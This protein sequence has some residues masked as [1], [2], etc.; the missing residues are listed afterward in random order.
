MQL[1][2]SQVNSK[3]RSSHYLTH[4]FEFIFILCTS[5]SAFGSLIASD[6]NLLKIG[7]ELSYPPFEMINH[8]GEPDGISVKMAQALGE[9]LHQEIDIQN[10]AFIGLVPALKVGIID[11]IISSLSIT[12]E[13]LHSI[14]FSDPYA[15]I[16]LSLLIQ[17]HSTVQ[18]IKDVDRKD[19]NVVVKA[20]TSGEAFARQHLISANV[21]I[22]DKETA[23]VLEVIQGKADVFIYDQLSVYT[24]W[25]KNPLTTRANLNPFKKEEWAVGIRKGNDKL[26]AQVNAF[27]KRF[28]KEDGFKKLG[29]QYLPVQ[30]RAFKEM[31]IPFLF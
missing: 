12:P 16:G 8:S 21:H 13:R 18:S 20:G 17:I 6:N 27:I 5:F 30:Y 23:C 4:F 25:Q 24:N 28:K 19:I 15:S 31:G 29:E 22:L 2:E 14:D 3:N 26:L 9:Y 7:M 1:C 11:L 10:I